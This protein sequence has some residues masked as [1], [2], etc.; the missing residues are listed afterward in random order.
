MSEP[1]GDGLNAQMPAAAGNPTDKIE[2]AADRGADAAPPDVSV[3]WREAAET[4]AT[5]SDAPA[6]EIAPAT[7]AATVMAAVDAPER[8]T[9]GVEPA[10][11]RDDV[12]PSEPIASAA[13]RASAAMA[14]WARAH[15][16]AP[17]AATVAIAAVL[18]AMAGALATAGLGSLWADAPATQAADAQPL[19]DAIARINADLL[20]LRSAIDS[21]GKTATSQL[22]RLGD[23]FDRFERAQAEPAAKLARLAEA[24]DRIDRRAPASGS[25]HDVTG[26]IAAPAIAAPATQP[27]AEPARAPGPPVLD[28]W[29]IRRVYNGAALIQGRLGAVVEVEPGDTLPGLGRIETIRRQDGRWVVVTSRGVILAR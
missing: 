28:G 12:R 13:R 2:I 25:A 21:S 14:E 16:R 17:R 26:S 27:A 23:R 7:A 4:D 19:R 18:G 22:A 20:A 24:V 6:P 15:L 10:A 3:A 8:A 29:V 5:A 9:I 1:K 11:P